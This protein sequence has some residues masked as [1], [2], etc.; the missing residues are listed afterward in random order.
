[1]QNDK[2]HDLLELVIQGSASEELNVESVIGYGNI[3]SSIRPSPATASLCNLSNEFRS[4]ELP[5]ILVLTALCVNY[6]H[7][8]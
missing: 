3:K 4:K 8:I 6:G 7:G 1:M 5:V 2:D